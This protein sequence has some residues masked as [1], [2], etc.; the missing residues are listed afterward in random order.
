MYHIFGGNSDEFFSG[1]SRYT[2]FRGDVRG[3]YQ[4]SVISAKCLSSGSLRHFSCKRIQT[5]YSK[6]NSHMTVKMSLISR[7]FTEV[8]TLLFDTIKDTIDTSKMNQHLSQK[9]L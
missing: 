6:I 4:I 2:R 7:L 8:D 3:I 9:Y 1:N 5:S